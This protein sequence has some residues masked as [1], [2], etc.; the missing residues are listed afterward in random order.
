DQKRLTTYLDQ[1]VKV[2]GKAYRFPLV[3]PEQATEKA[4]LILVAVKGHHLDE[5]IEQLRPFVGRETI[6][7]SLL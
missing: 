5:T 1:E 2:N 4:D 7:L 6:I 3:T